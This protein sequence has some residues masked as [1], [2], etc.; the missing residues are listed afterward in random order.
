VDQSYAYQSTKRAIQTKIIQDFENLQIIVDKFKQCKDVNEFDQTFKFE[1][2]KR[3]HNDV[4]SIKA[5]LEML[6]KWDGNVTKH[7]KNMDQKF[8]S[9]QPRKLRERLILRVKAEQGRMKEYL[10]DLANEKVRDC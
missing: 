7:I 3:D 10:F 5:H 9:C 2:F 8:I 1:E 4:E 6:Q